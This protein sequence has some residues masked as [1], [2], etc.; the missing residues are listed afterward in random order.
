M[1]ALVVELDTTGKRQRISLTKFEN[2]IKT[3]NKN[4]SA[5]LNKE[6]VK[7]KIQGF[8]ESVKR[9]IKAI[10]TFIKAP[11]QQ[12]TTAH[13]HELLDVNGDGQVDKD[14]FCDGIDKLHINTVTKKRL[15]DVFDAIDINNDGSLSVH[16]FS[17]FIE[18]TTEERR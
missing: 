13:L 5:S 8:D 11:A 6:D 2:Y 3:L 9:T 10:E 18:G 4:S 12:F 1:N 17:L 14:E 15:A 16:E 7:F